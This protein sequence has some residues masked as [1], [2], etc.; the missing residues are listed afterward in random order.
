M[1]GKHKPI[2]M[3]SRLVAVWGHKKFFQGDENVLILDCSNG[4][5]TMSIC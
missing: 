5:A 2:E 3:K 1:Y 4:C